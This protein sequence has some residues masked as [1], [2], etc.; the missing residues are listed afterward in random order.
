HGPIIG[1]R[2]RRLSSPVVLTGS[3]RLG[4]AR[5]RCRRQRLAVLGS[6]P[7]ERFVLRARDP[8]GRRVASVGSP[9]HPLRGPIRG[10][11]VVT[12]RS[13]VGALRVRHLDIPRLSSRVVAFVR[14]GYAPGAPEPRST[15]PF[16]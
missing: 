14:S 6:L 15:E 1:I 10:P 12:D 8:E 16:R 13:A 5:L 7:D 3:A 9:A 2:Q 11:P 4:P